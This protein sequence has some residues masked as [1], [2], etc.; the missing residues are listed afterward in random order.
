MVWNPT[1]I[2]TA[3]KLPI[4]ARV[5]DSVLCATGT[6]ISCAV[7]DEGSSSSFLICYDKASLNCQTCGLSR[8]P[9]FI[10]PLPT[11]EQASSSVSAGIRL[12]NSAVDV[13]RRRQNR[14]RHVPNLSGEPAGPSGEGG[15]DV[16]ADGAD[17]VDASTSI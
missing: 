2:G 4:G 10:V 14:S 8:E 6:L 9:D 16:E 3:I 7:S 12:L 1:P 13:D 15:S 5:Y 11:K 17:D